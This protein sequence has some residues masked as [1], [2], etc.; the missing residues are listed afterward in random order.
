[1]NKHI[2][3]Y[4]DLYLEREDVEYAT[5]LIG[6]WGCG[7]TFFIKNYIE[8]IQKS[9]KDK[10][11]FIYISLFGLKNIS[12]VKEAIFEELYSILSNKKIKFLGGAL[13]AAIK[14]GFNIDLIGDENKE[15]KINI[16]FKNIN[17]FE[18]TNY[19]DIIFIFDDLERTLIP[20][21]EILGFINSILDNKNTKVIVITNEN[22][23]KKE[24]EDIYKKFKEKIID[25]SFKV[26]PDKNYWSY[27]NDKYKLTFKKNENQIDLV[28]NIFDNFG[29]NNYRNINQC[30]DNYIYFTSGLDPY[31]LDNHKF[32]DLLIE[33]FYTLSLAHKKNDIESSLTLLESSEYNI[34]P[35]EI[36]SDIICG[37]N[38]N[39]EKLN[40]S[41]PKLA[42]FNK[43]KEKSWERLRHYREL[44]ETEF[45]IN[46]EDVKNK[47]INMYY[48]DIDIL[49][50]VISELIFFIKNKLCKNLSIND[51]D[52]KAKE[53]I[54]KFNEN[55]EIL[56]FEYL[57][58]NQTGFEYINKEDSDFKRISTLLHDKYKEIERD[59]KNQ[60]F[61]NDFYE[62]LPYIKVKNWN[63][64]EKKYEKYKKTSFLRSEHAEKIIN[65]LNESRDYTGLYNLYTF[66]N[67]R[68]QM[69]NIN[70]SRPPIYVLLEERYFVYELIH[71]LEEKSRKESNPFYKLKL[72][73]ILVMLKQL[74]E[75]FTGIEDEREDPSNSVI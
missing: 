27:F 30:T 2:E 29:D 15:T 18:K 50:M 72:D 36:W 43:T 3:K 35:R 73:E 48:N 12:S 62:L 28:K 71:C 7:K 51:I 42:I 13:K 14:L 20:I 75:R 8:N 47:F 57:A 39:Y 26:K 32:S 60:K 49:T 6:E 34:L 37:L 56:N 54:K 24:D 61:I 63:E 1:M 17:L 25:R 4:L 40:T 33:Q 59:R 68:Y 9:Q 66:L 11:K 19:E 67:K 31:L 65:L 38:I 53:Y 70:N 55:N 16:D 52:E 44:N 5:L 69:N 23:I 10:R 22:E 45:T 46:L 74:T 41:I 64:L 21:I 58:F